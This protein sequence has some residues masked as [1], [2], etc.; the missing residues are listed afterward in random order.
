[1]NYRDYIFTDGKRVRKP[2][3]SLAWKW[4][5]IVLYLFLLISMLWGCGMMMVPKYNYWTI[6][7][8][9]GQNVYKPGVFFE[10]LVGLGANIGKE[11]FF[12]V[13]N[14]QLYEY[15][16]LGIRTWAEAF[17]KTASPFYGFFVFPIAWLM[18]NLINGFGGLSNGAGIIGAIFLTSLLVRLITLMFSWKAQK[19]QDKMQLMQIKQAEI[20]AKYKNSNDPAAKQKQQMEMMQLYRKEG[21][22]PLSTIGASFLSIPFLIAMFTVVKATRD[23]KIASIGQISLIEKPWDM[24]QSGNFIYLLLLLVYLPIQIVSMILP[25]ILNLRKTKVIS[26]EQKK[27]RKR[28]F[29]M[30]GVMIIVFFVVTITIA[31]GVTIYWIF[32]AF[33]QILQTLAFHF[34]RIHRKTKKRD[35]STTSK[36]KQMFSRKTKLQTPDGIIIPTNVTKTKQVKKVNKAT[37]QPVKKKT[38]FSLG[39][40]KKKKKDNK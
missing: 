40:D 7:D 16:Y 3:Y 23:L 14:G 25:T 10:I 2:W 34:I 39:Q 36:F 8:A 30:Q 13:V 9:T 38:K 24:I 11:H 22:S 18:V 29:I 15:G 19:N 28:Q 33:I 20:Q 27:A 1:M 4:T 37:Y 32:S 12:H 31:A 5:K 17:T 21:V 26:K 35:G 6:M